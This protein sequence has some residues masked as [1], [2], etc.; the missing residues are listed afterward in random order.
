MDRSE[1]R[2]LQKAAR[3]GNK[4]AL[5]EWASR[6]E[7]QVRRELS[8]QYEDYYEDQLVGSIDN[9]IIAI[10]YTAVFSEATSW[11]KENINE[12]MRDLFATIDMFRTGQYTPEDY[13]EQ[14]KEYDINL[15]KIIT[16]NRERKSNDG[17]SK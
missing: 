15:D 6:F 7:D 5:G 17:N 11:T 9:F 8:K 14:L 3:D 2:R 16:H 13:I 10:C 1:I 4:L 12:Y